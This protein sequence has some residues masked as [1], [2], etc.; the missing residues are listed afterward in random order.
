M[1]FLLSWAQWFLVVQEPPETKNK[2]NGE[3]ARAEAI[4]GVEM[5]GGAGT[6]AELWASCRKLIN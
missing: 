3:E 4:F 2:G 5:L 6:A 1:P